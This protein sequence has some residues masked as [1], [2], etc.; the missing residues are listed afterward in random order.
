MV[1]RP[2]GSAARPGAFDVV[3]IER[4]ARI[5]PFEAIGGGARAGG[6]FDR[7]AREG[8][9]RP[10]RCVIIP[11]VYLRIARPSAML[12]RA[13]AMRLG[14]GF[15]THGDTRAMSDEGRC[16]RC[17]APGPVGTA[18]TADACVRLAVHRIPTSFVDEPSSDAMVGQQ[19]DAWLVLK[20]I[21]AGGVG[22][23]YLAEQRP[24]GLRAALKLLAEGDTALTHPERFMREAAALARLTHPN[25]VRLLA[26]GVHQ[27]RPYL[28]MEYIEGARTLDRV[29]PHLRPSEKC[30]VVMQL[31]NALGAA[32]AQG[33]VHR[34]LKPANVML[35][36]VVGE[37]HFVRVV[38]YGLAK[39]TDDPGHSTVVA[40]SPHY[41]APEQVSRDRIGPWTDIYALGVLTL[42][43]FTGERPFAGA[44][45]NAVLMLKND[46]AYDP[47]AEASAVLGPALTAVLS[48]ATAR[49]R[50][51]RYASIDAFRE[52]FAAMPPMI[53]PPLKPT[54]PMLRSPA[55]IALATA[56]LGSS[57]G[58]DPTAS[59]PVDV[60]SATAPM[61]DPPRPATDA[62][63][64]DRPP[65]AR[66][67]DDA[68]PPA[69]AR[70]RWRL[71]GPVALLVFIGWAALRGWGPGPDPLPIAPPPDGMRVGE[72]TDSMAGGMRDGMDGIGDGMRDGMVDGR[73]DGMA[74]AP[75][76]ALADA[77]VDAAV[78]AATNAAP[79]P[80]APS[81][82]ATRRP[83]RPPTPAPPAP[84]AGRPGSGLSMPSGFD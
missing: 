1:S 29:A 68:A 78:D 63:A 13:P 24:V 64:T 50:H 6:A 70:G 38:D 84:D 69:K 14:D 10:A 41:M 77:A 20:R 25:I 5:L 72:A 59:A 61:S 48:R 56:A 53:D 49:D 43:L 19:L 36:A 58:T 83:T 42:E 75:D 34:D 23:I 2:I 21:G 37:P 66:L 30:R 7:T 22:E 54:A 28:V 35:Q 52:A 33:V 74:P 27:Q 47:V 12:A 18:C 4:R 82:P 76:A 9:P 79:E 26:Y 44:T 67:Q 45:L 51:D 32:H 31:C 62:P 46:P 60:D 16:P 71:L 40:G 81:P 8:H 57:I 3:P 39:F 65:T 80:P 15:V 17:T 11:T 55:Q 73:T